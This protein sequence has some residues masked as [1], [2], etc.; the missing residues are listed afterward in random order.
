MRELMTDNAA[1]VAAGLAPLITAAR[2]EGEAIRRT[3]A[4]VVEALGAA[5]FLQMFLPR[6]L[7][8][9]ELPPLAAFRAIEDLSKAD[10]SVGWCAMIATVLSQ[11]TGWLDPNV[12]Q[13]IA[14]TPA[15]MRA[16]GSLRPQ[17]YAREVDGGYWVSGR[18]NFA[19]GISYADW[20]FC[21]CRVMDSDTPRLTQAGLP[22]TRAAWIP[23]A[24]AQVEDTW[25]VVGL[26]GTGS[27]DFVVNDVFVA[28]RIYIVFRRASV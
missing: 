5:G 9:P 25:Q 11:F 1:A 28:K 4:G 27:N 26:R 6:S 2:E 15:D 19:S 23:A 3:P 7:G 17:G 22:L 18:W 14:G 21:T 24:V 13:A 12:G 20:L 8:G 16:A 10:G